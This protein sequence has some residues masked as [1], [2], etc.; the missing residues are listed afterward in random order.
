[1]S[2]DIKKILIHDIS[3]DKLGDSIFKL[4]KGFE[5]RETNQL[6]KDLKDELKKRG[7]ELHNAQ[8]HDSRS[9]DWIIFYDISRFD[10]YKKNI[11]KIATDQNTKTKLAAILWEAP[12][13]S[14]HQYK[15]S[16]LKYFDKVFTW[17]KDLID[18][19]KFFEYR[20]PEFLRENAPFDVQFIDKKF[21]V[22]INANK[23]VL[24][25]EELYSERKKAA[26]FFNETQERIDVYGP[27]WNTKQLKFPV[28][29]HIALRWKFLLKKIITFD[30]KKLKDILDFVFNLKPLKK[31]TV[32]GFV[33][34]STIEVLSKYKF[35]IC[36][37]NGLDIPGYST[38]KIFNC[39]NARCIP[40]Y[41]GDKEIQKHI[42]EGC[43]IDMRKFKDY[44]VLYRFL[45]GINKEKYNE[46]IKTI[47]KYLKEEKNGL[48][49]NKYFVNKFC[50]N[51]LEE[52]KK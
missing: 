7:Y 9:A 26:N 8:G 37:E 44:E 36:F 12:M 17:K 45:K 20:W 23:I 33:K 43:Y 6:F 18:G 40:I 25:D 29:G 31:E 41:L 39:L 46:Y 27:R 14:N 16:L 42:P 1:M 24:S 3:L 19:K 15:K 47:N 5:N 21:L 4:K 52:Q 11:K 49:S 48:Y 22:M 30:I 10:N 50:N 35:A 32:K 13:I 34:E 38:E 51:L 28:M 2:N